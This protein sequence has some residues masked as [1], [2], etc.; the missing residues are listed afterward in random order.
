MP[1]LKSLKK[2]LR[3]KVHV[4]LR[5]Q[6]AKADPAAPLQVRDLFLA[7]FKD[8]APNAIIAGTM[9]IKGEMDPRPLMQALSEKGFHLCLPITGVRATPLIFRA[10]KMGD[11]LEKGVWDIPAPT[12]DQPL[13]EPDILLCPLLAFDR[14]G[15]RLG[16]GGGYYDATLHQ[17]RVKKTIVAIGLGYAAQEVEEVP[18]G[19]LDQKLDAIVTEKEIIIPSGQDNR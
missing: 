3:E 15:G 17:L 13:C 5:T 18:T 19:G 10:Y 4:A 12:T 9:P 11:R 2:K 1:D 8:M 6:E 14:A 7:H 16:Y